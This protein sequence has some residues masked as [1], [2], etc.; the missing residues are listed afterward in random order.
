[1]ATIYGLI[2]AQLRKGANEGYGEIERVTLRRIGVY[3][4]LGGNL[5]W[6]KRAAARS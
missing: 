4:V 5:I 3:V 6:A 1:L 2:L